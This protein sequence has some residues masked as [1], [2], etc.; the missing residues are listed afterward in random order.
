MSTVDGFNAIP[1]YPII[2]PV[3]IKGIILGTIEIN[4]ILQE[5]KRI[6]IRIPIDKIA[7][8]KLDIKLFTK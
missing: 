1:K 2:P 7:K 4:T 3:T 6:A 8:I 5:R